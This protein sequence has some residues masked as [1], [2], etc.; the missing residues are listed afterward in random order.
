MSTL[1]TKPIICLFLLGLATLSAKSFAVEP[2]SIGIGGL[3]GLGIYD[4]G[5]QAT[6]GIRFQYRFSPEFEI[7]AMNNYATLSSAVS[8]PTS[9]TVNATHY[10]LDFSYHFAKYPIWVGPRI[11]LWVLNSNAA[12][13]MTNGIAF[14]A[15]SS[16]LGFEWGPAGGY[17]YAVNDNFS[18]GGDLSF[19]NSS[20]QGVWVF[21]VQVM[22]SLKYYF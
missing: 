6:Y 21:A 16:I 10:N 1:K 20:I 13:T 8:I 17:D 22:G 19:L 4:V 3:L 7:G 2:P 15:P 18:V 5:V 11:G 9:I 14:T 12:V